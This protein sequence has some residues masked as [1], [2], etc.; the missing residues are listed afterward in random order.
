[1]F[2]QEVCRYCIMNLQQSSYTTIKILQYMG[3]IEN[4]KVLLFDMKTLASINLFY[5]VDQFDYCG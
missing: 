2:I 1:M 4:T 5:L 3:F